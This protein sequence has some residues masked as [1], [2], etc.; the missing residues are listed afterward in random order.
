MLINHHSVINLEKEGR[1]YVE[2]DILKCSDTVMK[3][4]I[5]KVDTGADCTTIS[6]IDLSRLGYT[7]QWIYRN[8][9]PFPGKLSNANEN[10][11]DAALIKIPLIN[12]LGHEVKNMPFLVIKESGRDF[13]NLLG[14]DLLSAFNYAFNNDDDVFEISRAKTFKKRDAIYD[15]VEIYSVMN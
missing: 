1:A 4:V 15:D 6:K 14:L 13:R 7:N 5:F 9:Q 8:M 11:V 12:I 2:I 3:S 10:V